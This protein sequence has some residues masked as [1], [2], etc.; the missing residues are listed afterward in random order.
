MFREY[1]I[2]GM[3]C[4]HCVD[5]VT[6]NLNKHPDIK[7]A[8]VFL[9]TETVA[10]EMNKDIPLAELQETISPDEIYV[11]RNKMSVVKEIVPQ[12]KNFVQLILNVLKRIFTK[13][14]CCKCIIIFSFALTQK[15]FAQNKEAGTDRNAIKQY[16]MKKDSAPLL[17]QEIKRSQT[18]SNAVNSKTIPAIDV[19]DLKGKTVNTATFS[20]D[21]KPIVIVFW[22]S[23]HKYPTKELDAIQ[24]NYDEWKKETG[25]KVIV[26]SIDDSR[27]SS[28]VLPMVKAREWEFEFYLD[29]N[30]DF[31]RAMNVNFCPQT[32]FINGKGEIVS[33]HLGFTEGSEAVIYEELKK[34]K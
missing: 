3:T 19:K 22:Y 32:F 10:I 26:I 24:E 31:K 13:Q 33:Q 20:N 28:N 12:K 9:N 8:S 14:N 2:E 15:T 6:S 5:K 27:S 30:S 17:S 4:Q 16:I 34:V 18:D 23:V 29:I 1:K 11:I 7:K 21:G 25:V